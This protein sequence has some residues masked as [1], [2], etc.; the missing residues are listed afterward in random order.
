V[1]PD[2]ETP[3]AQSDT[4]GVGRLEEREALEPRGLW[5]SHGPRGV[6]QTTGAFI[7]LGFLL[8]PAINAFAR[9]GTALHHGL[10]IAGAVAF[11]GIYAALVLLWRT[12]SDRMLLVLFVALVGIASALTLD[13]GAAWGFLFTYCAACAG[14]ISARY[15]FVGVVGCTVLAG[16]L[17]SLGGASG[18]QVIGWVASTAGIGTLILVMRDLRMR[19]DELRE[20]RAELARMA[21]AEE[22]ERFAR[23]LHDLLGHSLSL[24][25]LKSEL[26]GRLLPERPQE[27]A[28]ELADVE[29][30]A[31]EALGEVREAV[32]GYRRPTLD[33]ELEG[34]RVALAAAD[35]R[36]SVEKADVQLEPDR[37]AVLAWAV[38]E[39]VTNVIRHSRARNV[40]VHVTATAGGSRVEV[41]DDGVGPGAGGGGGGNGLA[42]LEQRARDVGGSLEAG[43][44][45]GGGFRLAVWVP[46]GPPAERPAGAAAPQAARR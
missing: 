18:G 2:R 23:D 6:A 30:V 29:S 43:A 39:G 15:G 25:A 10:E 32:S 13:D 31:R 17:S 34:A 41:T 45:P 35:I 5:F 7:W 46:E 20:A 14:L 42:G 40:S 27:A 22:R 3:V 9:H 21:V 8:F 44:L 19:N 38:R 12:R 26:A 33:G 1:S 36:G 4:D 16:V 28:R 11:V 24:I 37:E